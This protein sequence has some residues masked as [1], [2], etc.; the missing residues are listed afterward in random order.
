MRQTG[1]DRFDPAEKSSFWGD[2]DKL[3]DDQGTIDI[4]M[5]LGEERRLQS[6]DAVVVAMVDGASVF[7]RI[8]DDMPVDDGPSRV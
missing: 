5:T 3:D 7:G 1:S 2:E 6:L 4:V 8:I